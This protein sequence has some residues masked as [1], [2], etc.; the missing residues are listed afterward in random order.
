VAFVFFILR[1]APKKPQDLGPKFSAIGAPASM[2]DEIDELERR[3]S[4]H[5][6][7]RRHA[8]SGAS[9]AG[10][11][12]PRRPTLWSRIPAASER[13]AGASIVS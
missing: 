6:E 7:D 10:S 12:A 8:P 3:R 11:R 2:A 13:I 1:S 4:R 5:Q 9:G